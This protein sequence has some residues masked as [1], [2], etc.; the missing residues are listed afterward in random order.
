M[1][2]S[3]GVVVGVGIV[4]VV[5]LLPL[6]LGVLAYAPA[7]FVAALLLIGTAVLVRPRGPAAPLRWIPASLGLVAFLGGVVA[8]LR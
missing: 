8:S 4:M 2:Q 1:S 3:N 6:V 5:L 7:A